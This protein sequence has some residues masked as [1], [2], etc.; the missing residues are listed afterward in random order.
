MFSGHTAPG[1][2]AFFSVGPIVFIL[3]A[4][5]AIPHFIMAWGLLH[6]AEW[7]RVAGIILSILSLFHP[8]IGLGTAIAIYS[9]I[10][11]FSTE[12]TELLRRR[13]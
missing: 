8:V 10:I 5:F 2:L 7:A 1:F 11:L 4:V 6:G 3:V 13:A 9:L 12:T